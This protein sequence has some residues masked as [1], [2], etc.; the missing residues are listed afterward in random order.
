M[1]VFVILSYSVKYGDFA[2]YDSVE[3]AKFLYVWL[4]AL[5]ALIQPFSVPRSS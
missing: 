4:Y 3:C 5:I 2:E 1:I